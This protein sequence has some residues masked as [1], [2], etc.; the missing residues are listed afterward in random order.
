MPKARVVIPQRTRTL[1][2]SEF[3]HRC[4]ICGSNRP[5][6]HH[7]DEDPSNNNPLNLVP[8]CPNCHLS[9]QH[10]PTEGIPAGVLSLFRR[11]KDPAI[12][13][14]QFRPLYQRLQF[15]FEISDNSDHNQLGAAAAELACFVGTLEMGNFYGPKVE[16]LTKQIT[17]GGW[18]GSFY[19][20]EPSPETARTLAALPERNRRRLIENREQV[21][22][23]CIE[24]LRYQRWAPP[25]KTSSNGA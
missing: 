11:F 25:S 19:T 12:L 8:L 24:L 9:D 15:L 6:L 3:N 10:S 14:P 1:V 13:S 21:L 18:S 7:L 22:Q 23:L 2:L 20:G 17:L 4:A 16:G 5:Q